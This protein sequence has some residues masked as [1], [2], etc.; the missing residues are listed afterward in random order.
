MVTWPIT[1]LVMRLLE[2]GDY[3]VYA[4]ALLVSGFITLFSELGL[5]V[6]LVQ[7]KEL[8]EQQARMSVSLVLILNACIA[9]S[10]IGLAPIVAVIFDEPDVTLVM[11]VLTLELLMTAMATVPLAMLERSLLFRQV[12]LGHL[13]GGVT[14]SVVTLIVAWMDAGVW[15]LVAGTLSAAFV[16]SIAWIMFYGRVVL[17]GVLR[18][19]AI[20]PMVRIGGHTLATRFLWYWSGQADQLILGRL[21]HASALGVYN[22]SAQLAM[23]PAGKVMEAVNRVAFPVLS[24]LQSNPAGL[25]VAYRDSTALLSLYAFGA[26]W[27]LAAVSPEFVGVVLGEKWL[28]ATLPLAVLATVAPLRMLCAFNNTM[29]TAVGAPQTAT[30]EQVLACVVIPSAVGFGA[31]L[32]GLDGAAKAWLAAYPP[33]FLFS[34]WLTTYAM[35]A[36]VLMALRAVLAPVVAGLCMLAAVE[37]MRAVMGDGA[38]PILRLTALI[39]VGACVYLAALGLIARSLLLHAWTLLQDLLRPKSGEK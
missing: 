23:L 10:I 21:L 25:R 19:Q 31:Y 22:V 32:D 35:H 24:R 18:L 37:G 26:C 11:R 34:V 33:V 8:T 20:R 2:P 5:G 4:I 39:G 30:Y 12:S 36:S 15:A 14:G 27:G 38:S 16:R 6:A 1:I 17:P 7:A 9:L 3:G 29:A 28:K 13:A